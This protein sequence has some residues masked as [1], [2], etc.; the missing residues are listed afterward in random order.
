[1]S[2]NIEMNE[3]A[4]QIQ[5]LATHTTASI[6]SVTSDLLVVIVLAG[7]LFVFARYIGRGPFVAL[8]ISLYVG[9]ALYVIFPF[10]SYLPSAPA[11]TAL[12]SDVALF[13]ILSAIAYFILRRIVVSDFISV[14][15]IGLVILSLLGA[16]FILALAYQVFPVRAVHIFTPA[17][18]ALFAVK[19]YFFWW[20]AGPIIGLFFF[21]R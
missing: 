10:M 16:G 11:F 19:N 4:T 14:G 6:T 17:V 21:A 1:M 7:A 2:Y 3:T 9:L 15:T 18:D 8:L 13:S 20:I 5:T 12:I